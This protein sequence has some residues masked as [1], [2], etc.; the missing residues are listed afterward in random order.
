[1]SVHL[2]LLDQ[3]QLNSRVHTNFACEYSEDGKIFLLLENGVCVLTLRGCME[4]IFPKF[5]FKKDLITLSS[6]SIS[7]N[8]DLNLPSFINDLSR[9]NLYEAV[10]DIGLSGNIVSATDV[11][12]KPVH[13][14]WTPRGIVEKTEGALA[15]LTNLHNIEIYVEV[16]DENEINSFIRVANFSKDISEYY[17]HIWKKLDNVNADVK[18]LELKKRVDQ[19]TPT[20]FTW[21]HVILKDRKAFCILFVGHRDGAISAWKFVERKASEIYES[22][23]QFLERYNTKLKQ[24]ASLHWYCRKSDAGGLSVG[25]I[26]G[27]IGAVSVAKLST[28]KIKFS[29]EVVFNS[30]NDLKVDKI[31]IINYQNITYLVAAKQ[32]YIQVYAINEYGEVV[33]GKLRQV[34]NLYIT[35][36]LHYE[37]NVLLVLSLCGQL[38]QIELSLVD[39]EIFISERLLQLHIDT[40]KYRTHGFLFSPNK[41]FLGILTYPC[42]LKDV[43]KGKNFVNFF[44]FM[45]KTKDAFQTLMN[46][47]ATSLRDYWD[48]FETLRVN[49]LQEKVFPWR[50][51]D[52]NINYDALPLLKLK[53]LRWIAK[54]SEKIYP[55]ISRVEEYHIKAY[56]LLNYAVDI[57][58]AVE[59]M[60]KLLNIYFS[61]KKL[62]LFQMQSLDLLNFFLKEM[63]VKEILTKANLGETFIDDMYNVMKI[64]NELQYPPMP[65]CFWCGE[66]IIGT[67]CI[68]YH[69]DS[70]CAISLIPINVTPGYKCSFCKCVVSKEMDREYYPIFCP[71]CDI[72]MKRRCFDKKHK[73]NIE[74][75]SE[76]SKLDESFPSDC[77]NDCVKEEIHFSDI[78]ENS[79]DYLVLTDSEEER[80]DLV[81]EL[82]SKI[83][84]IT[85]TTSPEEIEPIISS[86]NAGCGTN[87]STSHQNVKSNDDD[88]EVDNEE[89]DE[90]DAA[91]DE[92]D[93]HDDDEDY[94]N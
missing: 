38:K 51:I 24:I 3:I 69:P 63:V 68:P 20:A 30:E 43:S 66:K 87:Q 28:D 16:I 62:S 21:S 52:R 86:S 92:Y 48:C 15:V 45:N 13:A 37:K 14:M 81:K 34:G 59:R 35:G 56:V 47:S 40:N 83:K 65:Q 75:I 26:N 4:N 41:V 78:E 19:I 82:Y 72:P 31:T 27:H 42:Q 57:K 64:A 36:L 91:E 89:D 67:S 18:F 9:H 70:R 61:E 46:I 49:C 1:M 8:L 44:I 11:A 32:N 2:K 84:K 54:L 94:L 33:E 80:D 93:G 85:L 12:P 10:L 55:M 6:A 71:Y 25:D 73:K 88:D 39:D 60:T 58:L 29:D 23:L 17:R 22:K 7:E 76:T 79:V 74:D 53:I 90:N 50:N 77:C 5:S